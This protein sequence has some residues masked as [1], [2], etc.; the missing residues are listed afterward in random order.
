MALPKIDTP[1]FTLKL[2]SSD[3]K[4]NIKFRPFTVKEEKIPVS[5]THLRAHET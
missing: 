4:K 2:P 5:Y 1:V 3:G